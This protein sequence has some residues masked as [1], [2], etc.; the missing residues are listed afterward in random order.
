MSDVFSKK[1][2]SQIMSRVRGTGNER[3]ELALVKVLRGYKI[4]GWRRHRLLLGKP[5]FVFRRERVVVFVDGCFWH[6][7]PLHSSVPATNRSFW[8]RK[9]AKNRERDKQVN[10][11]LAATGWKVVRIWQHEL[12]RTNRDRLARKITKALGRVH[13]SSRRPR[14]K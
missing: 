1:R 9:L 4:S 11:L 6:S 12:I 7:C 13:P 3:T 5:D 2:R 14:R 10:V 8:V